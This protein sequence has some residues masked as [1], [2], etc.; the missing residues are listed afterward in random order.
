MTAHR[1][2]TAQ[3][4]MIIVGVIAPLVF[5]AMG[6]IAI[7]AALSRLPEAVAVHWGVSG[8]PDRFGTPVGAVVLLGVL[9]LAFAGLGFAV[10]RLSDEVVSSVQRFILALAPSLAG[11]LA[12]VFAS[13]IVLQAGLADGHDAPSILPA[14]LAAVLIGGV[15]WVAAWFALPRPVGQPLHDSTELPVIELGADERVSWIQRL[16]PSRTVGTLVVGI[17]AVSLVGGGVAMALLAPVTA[18]VIWTVVMLAAGSSPCRACSGRC[19][20]TGG[21][22]SCGPCWD[23][24]VSRSHQPRWRRRPRQT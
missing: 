19:P 20:S 5:T 22:L 10:S 24:P 4:R 11:F 13:S 9:G 2:R 6:I 15:I 18:F 17:L 14:M 8:T 21:V 12:W 3:A 16:E 1:T 7:I 23:S